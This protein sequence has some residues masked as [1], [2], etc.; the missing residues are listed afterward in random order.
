M[1]TNVYTISKYWTRIGQSLL[2]ATIPF[3]VTIRGGAE[4][5]GSE[6]LPEAL[7]ITMA[8][9]GVL[10]FSI[11]LAALSSLGLVYIKRLGGKCVTQPWPADIDHVNSS[12][13]TL[14]SKATLFLYVTFP[15]MAIV[16]GI[17]R[18]MDSRIATW[19][20]NTILVD[21][22]IYSR[23]Y[24]HV[25]GCS[26]PPCFRIHPNHGFE[27]V[28]YLTDGILILSLILCFVLLSLWA[29]SILKTKIICQR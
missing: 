21:D 18:Y 4:L 24:A 25:M 8:G 2:I 20:D 22:F 13:D 1:D 28:L 3:I 29:A 23:L 16:A 7:Q 10:V 5:I 14:I 26:N 9:S 17:I 27:Y 12:R 6:N 19:H 11:G 15:L